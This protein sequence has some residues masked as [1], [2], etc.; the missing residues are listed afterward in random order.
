MSAVPTTLRNSLLA[1]VLLAGLGGGAYVTNESTPDAYVQAVAA[2]RDVSAAVKI[3]MVMGRTYESGGRHIGTPYTDKLGKGQ[4]LTVCNGI[5][6]PEVVVGRYYNPAECYGLEK[7]RYLHHEAVA[8]G[9]L[10]H[11][12]EYDPFQQAT[13]LDFIHNKGD[14]NF[15]TSSMRRK[16]NAGDLMG[17]CR[18]NPRWNKGTVAGVSTVLPGLVIRGN[19]NDEIC[20]KWRLGR[21]S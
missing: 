12:D 1:L 14:G 4:P 13:F 8:R 19:S 11:W 17:A 10:I 3:A 15:E 18:E 6:G 7:R 20:R 9:L 21:M 16:A 5:T 2:D